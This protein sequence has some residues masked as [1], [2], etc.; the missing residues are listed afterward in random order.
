MGWTDEAKVLEALGLTVADPYVGQAVAG[1][2]AWAPNKRREAG[3]RAEDGSPE[4]PDVAPNDAVALGATLY[5]VALYNERGA[6]DSHASFTELAGYTPTGTMGQINR[7]LGIGRAAV[8]PPPAPDTVTAARLRRHR[9][10]LGVR[11]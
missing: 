8:D 5:A 11:W 4:D 6:T 3:Y 10:V 1:A 2:N 9:R 7:L